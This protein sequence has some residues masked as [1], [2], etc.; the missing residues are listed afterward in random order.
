MAMRLGASTRW[1][2]SQFTKLIRETGSSLP[3][4]ANSLSCARDCASG[5]TLIVTVL[6]E[7]PVNV[8]VEVGEQGVEIDEFDRNLLIAD[9]PV[10]ALSSFVVVPHHA[11]IVDHKGQPIF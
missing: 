1:N 3:L 8:R 11:D 10:I 6:I 7:P 9:V 2:S 4:R 5:I